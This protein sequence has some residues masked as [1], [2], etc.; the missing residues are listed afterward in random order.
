MGALGC[1]VKLARP[2][3][4]ASVGSGQT[5]TGQDEGQVPAV[6]YA[7]AAEALSGAQLQ[8]QQ[9][10]PLPELSSAGRQVVRTTMDGSGVSVTVRT[11]EAVAWV[12]GACHRHACWAPVG[13]RRVHSEERPHTL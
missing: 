13:I 10:A 12:H 8:R 4:G 3:R 11:S 7:D 5:V 6:C 9:R 1:G 2:C